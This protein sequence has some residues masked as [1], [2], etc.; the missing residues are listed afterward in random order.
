MTQINFTIPCSFDERLIDALDDLNQKHS[1]A[2]VASE[3][4]GSLA[5]APVPSSRPSNIL[6]EIE[7]S[8]LEKFIALC[9]AKGIK[10]SY[11]QN[12][13]CMGSKEHTLER[14]TE[15]GQFFRD[16]VNTGIDAITIT[17]PYLMEIFHLQSPKIPITVST[18]AN[19]SSI[20][21][22]RRYKENGASKIC[23]SQDS[24]RDFD[25]INAIAR[26][27]LGVVVVLNNPCLHMCNYQTY[28]YLLDSHAFDTGDG[29][30]G[31]NPFPSIKC[32]L[33]KLEDLSELIKSRWIRPSDIERHYVGQGV[34]FFKISGRDKGTDWIIEATTQYM[35]GDDTNFYRFI[36]RKGVT[37]YKRNPILGT[38][39]LPELIITVDETQL[40]DFL[41]YWVDKRPD[42]THYE[43]CCGY[44][45]SIAKKA[46]MVNDEQVRQQYIDNVR[47][48]IQH[49]A[50]PSELTKKDYDHKLIRR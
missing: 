20:Q 14:A 49:L 41:K 13:L 8:E 50:T 27:E 5:T 23:I 9:H 25:L 45:D 26:M 3:V 36:E 31:F 46:I 44:C 35:A 4:Y 39:E 48:T 47:Q 43:K 24:N 29:G 22:V 21:H 6:P 10:F 30:A 19:T 32:K 11:T 17:N 34:Q 2:K 18:I 28:H 12:G 40:G 1:G 16:I 38:A 33:K 15:I 37:A 7:M 42:C